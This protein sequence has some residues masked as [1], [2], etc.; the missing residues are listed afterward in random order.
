MLRNSYFVLCCTLRTRWWWP[1]ERP[2]EGHL[3][4]CLLSKLLCTAYRNR[5]AQSFEAGEF[6]DDNRE[7]ADVPIQFIVPST[8]AW[9]S[10]SM[11]HSKSNFAARASSLSASFH[12]TMAKSPSSF[13]D[14]FHVH[15]ASVH[16]LPVSFHS[17][18]SHSHPILLLPIPNQTKP[19]Q[20]DQ[21]RSDQPCMHVA[22][23]SPAQ[24]SPGTR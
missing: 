2:R 19:N 18:S 10:P 4:F 1:W 3:E 23:S 8:S 21:I 9:P 11:F 12:H 17:I 15:S 16:V 5:V 6:E 22:P 13:L 14:F 24:P 20:T 7:D